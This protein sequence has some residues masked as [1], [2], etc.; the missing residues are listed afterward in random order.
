[1]DRPFPPQ[2]FSGKPG[3]LNTYT[4]PQDNLYI[5]ELSDC[6]V[7]G[8]AGLIFDVNGNI[9]H[10]DDHFFSR[11][12]VKPLPV[13]EP[14][15]IKQF[16]MLISAVQ[17]YSNMYYHFTVEIL[18][19]I[20]SVK[21]YLDENPDAK[22]L[23]WDSAF[24]RNYLE[25]IGISADR[26]EPYDIGVRYGWSE[27]RRKREEREEQQQERVNCTLFFFFFFFF[28][29]PRRYFADKLIYPAPVPRITPCRESIMATRDA[30]NV[31]VLPEEERNIV[32]YLSRRNE[33]NRRIDNEDELLQSLRDSL[34]GEEIVVYD[35][36]P[37]IDQVIDLFQRAKMVV[38]PHGAGFSHIIFTAPG[39]K[40]GGWG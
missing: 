33:M 3:S 9:F 35:S 14:V 28:P 4:C 31:T 25:K 18:P 10:D 36:N 5:A 19:R 6:Y 17:K 30:L 7:E 11:L 8:P 12:E 39:T 29:F 40:V 20:I 15:E 2:D 32:V 16:S 23:I 22:L 13:E 21:H 27:W 1:M 24:I 38:G 37:D 34:P 26:I